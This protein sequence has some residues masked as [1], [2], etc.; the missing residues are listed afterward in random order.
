MFFCAHPT[1]SE[2]AA[3]NLKMMKNKCV[4]RLRNLI[5]IQKVLC[6]LLARVS[7]QLSRTVIFRE[8]APSKN[9]SAGVN[10]TKPC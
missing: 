8:T 6:K 9:N 3:M 1:K 7:K 5:K 10:M 2:Q 4:C